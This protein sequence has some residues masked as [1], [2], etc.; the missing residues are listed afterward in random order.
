MLYALKGFEINK[1][2]K[3]NAF[4]IICIFQTPPITYS[5]FTTLRTPQSAYF[6]SNPESENINRGT[7]P[8]QERKGK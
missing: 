6:P 2:V 8:F 5:I 7:I 4:S 3:V 1:S